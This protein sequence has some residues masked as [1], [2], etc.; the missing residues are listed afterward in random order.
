MMKNPYV[1]VLVKIIKVDDCDVQDRIVGYFIVENGMDWL[2]Q[3]SF[4][5]LTL[6][7]LILVFP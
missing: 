6:L 3:I 7:G 1:V 4:I 2:D 5:I